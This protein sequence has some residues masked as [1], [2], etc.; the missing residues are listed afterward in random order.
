MDAVS[1][2][3]G[4]SSGEC[5]LNYLNGSSVDFQ[6]PVIKP[7]TFPVT[8]LTTTP[9]VERFDQFASTQLNPNSLYW[10]EVGSTAMQLSNGEFG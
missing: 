10:I 3:I 6:G 2:T 5:R 8:G 9:Q 7:V 1:A 4:P